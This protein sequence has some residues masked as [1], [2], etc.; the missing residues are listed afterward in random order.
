M[1]VSGET[2]ISLVSA[3]MNLQSVSPRRLNVVIPFRDFRA[4]RIITKHISRGGEAYY[5]T[6][7]RIYR[8]LGRQVFGEYIIL[9]G[10]HRLSNVGEFPIHGLISLNVVESF[11]CLGRGPLKAS[12][13]TGCF[14]VVK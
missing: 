10:Q 4:F 8:I 2:L 1:I 9:N 12:V 11:Y 6:G 3:R 7:I 13:H 5:L 14:L